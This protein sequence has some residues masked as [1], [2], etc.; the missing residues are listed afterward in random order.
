MAENATERYD[1]LAAQFYRETGIM[2]PGKD[3]AAALG[4]SMTIEDRYEAW[5]QWCAKSAAPSPSGSPA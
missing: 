2:A 5:R 1:R 4:T 3:V